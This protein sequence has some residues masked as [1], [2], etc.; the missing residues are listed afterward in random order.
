MCVVCPVKVRRNQR[1][2]GASRFS[3][4]LLDASIV[5]SSQPER[6][7]EAPL[8]LWTVIEPISLKMI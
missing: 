2:D 6:D 7:Q 5:M 3:R 1:K 4:P 8:L